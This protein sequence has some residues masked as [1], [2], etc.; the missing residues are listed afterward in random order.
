MQVRAV[1]W[2]V[3]LSR[4][5][6]RWHDAICGQRYHPLPCKSWAV[7]VAGWRARTARSLCAMRVTELIERCW[8]KEKDVRP[9][10]AEALKLIR[11]MQAVS[12]CA[13][14]RACV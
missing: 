13:R 7:R 10:A 12:E 4:N 11:A 9:T 5:R 8:Q 6:L 2:C 3:S 14:V 1:C